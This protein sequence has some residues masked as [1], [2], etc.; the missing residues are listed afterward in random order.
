MPTQREA[1]SLSGDQI[2]CDP[3]AEEAEEVEENRDLER[4]DLIRV[5]KSDRDFG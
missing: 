3:E 4:L 5:T 1:S 2:E